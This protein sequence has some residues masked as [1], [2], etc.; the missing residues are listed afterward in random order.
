MDSE[1]NKDARM[2]KVSCCG[3]GKELQNR[4]GHTMLLWVTFLQTQQVG[5][6]CQLSTIGGHVVLEIRH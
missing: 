5:R 6:H 3:L 1:E 2:R 4:E